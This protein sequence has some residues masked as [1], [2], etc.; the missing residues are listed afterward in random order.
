MIEGVLA[1]LM[2]TKKTR[3]VKKNKKNKTHARSYMLAPNIH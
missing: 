3:T 1:T 2:G